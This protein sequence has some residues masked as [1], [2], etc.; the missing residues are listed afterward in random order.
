MDLYRQKG[1][2]A[3]A[4]EPVSQLEH[5][6]Q[7]AQLAL[8]MSSDPEVVLAA[9][10]H[11]IGHLCSGE[12]M[13]DFG[14]LAHEQ[15]GA[16]FLR[17][18]GVPER[19]VQLVAHHVSAKRYLTFKQPAY[20]AQL[21]EASLETLKWQGGPMSEEEASHFEKDPDFDIILQLRKW[22]EAAKVPSIPLPDLAY[23][24]LLMAAVM[25]TNKT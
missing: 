11:D 24:E 18:H 4:G 25:K 7:S 21:S 17:L 15:V 22:D 16:Q 3:Y 20:L 14:T 9:F 5:A 19:V 23:F 13:S 2:T 8:T 10:L 6:C 1:H 12:Q